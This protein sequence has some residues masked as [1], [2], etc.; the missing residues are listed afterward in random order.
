MELKW[1]GPEAAAELGRLFEEVPGYARRA[2]PLDVAATFAALPPDVGPEDKFV[3]G[4]FLDGGL[5]G[6]A[7]LIRGY[8]EPGT[9]MLGL[10]LIS[11]RLQGRGH[12]RRAYGKIEDLVRDWAGVTKVRIG[13]ADTNLHVAPFWEKM[14]F[15]D[16]GIRNS[17]KHVFEKTVGSRKSRTKLRAPLDGMAVPDTWPARA[18]EINDGPALGLLQERA[19]RG[20]VDDEGESPAQF[21]AE[22]LATLG[23]KYGPFLRDASFFLELDGAAASAS[24]VTLWKGKPLLAF[25]V[26]DPRFQRRGIGKF[27]IRKS[28]QAL[29]ALGYSVLTLVVTRGNPAERLY[30]ELGFHENP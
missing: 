23:G 25:Y 14:G 11:E 17:G 2:G 13:V 12:G 8:P 4:I 3:Q 9:A 18:L 16:I 24:L 15:V 19:Y 7:D 21:V 10:L 5:V 30:R 26:T 29:A 1:I 28:M 20:T 6:C 27:L 22:T